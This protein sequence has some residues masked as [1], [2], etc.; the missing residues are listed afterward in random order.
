MQFQSGYGEVL[1]DLL[2]HISHRF[3]NLQALFRLYCFL[4]ISKSWITNSITTLQCLQYK[5]KKCHN[6]KSVTVLLQKTTEYTKHSLTSV[7]VASTY[8]KFDT[9]SGWYRSPNP[10]SASHTHL[11]SNMDMAKDRNSGIVIIKP[12]RRTVKALFWFFPNA[13]A[14]DCFVNGHERPPRKS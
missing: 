9:S 5:I 6:Q 14:T 2:R 7:V 4:E 1:T 3:Q 13:V 12:S 11:Q 10:C 8:V